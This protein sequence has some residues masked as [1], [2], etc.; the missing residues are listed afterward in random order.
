M[1]LAIPA[2]ARIGGV[3]SLGGKRN[4]AR[5]VVFLDSQNV[6]M[7]A[8]EE[9]AFR[10]APSR[11]G[12]TDP[13][14]LARLI[15]AK[16]RYP[17]RLSGVRVYRGL[18][19]SQRQPEANAAN[20]RQTEVHEERGDGLVAVFTRP[21]RYPRGWPSVPAEEKGVD[22]ALA[23]DFVNMASSGA[24]DVGV[25]MST[26]TD[27]LPALG[28]VAAL[29]GRPHPRGEV[30]AWTRS[31][32]GARRLRPRGAHVWCHWLDRDDFEAVRDDTDYNVCTP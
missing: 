2:S 18:P 20:L 32:V 1:F 6:Y 19:D 29:G 24:Y 30:A 31:A 17:S 5:V 11:L 9:Y 10:G 7:G 12:Q 27:L 22:V 14:A 21:L 15:V 28:A 23:V 25:L 4:V 3:Y 26:D 16:R 8:R 13:L